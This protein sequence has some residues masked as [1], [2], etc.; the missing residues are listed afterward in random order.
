MSFLA[1]HMKDKER[2][3]S[4]DLAEEEE[5]DDEAEESQEVPPEN[6]SR[7]SIPT[8]REPTPSQLP[9]PPKQRLARKNPPDSASSTVML[10]LIH[11]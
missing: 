1:C 6:Y 5:D 8:F 9:V 7:K 10:S 4:V 2:L 11:I 3:V